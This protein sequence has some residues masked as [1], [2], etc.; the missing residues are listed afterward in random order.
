MHSGKLSSLL[1][2]TSF[3]LAFF[4]IS[5]I[6]AAQTGTVRGTV[7]DPNGL[8][9]A[10]A[11][12]I[13]EGTK[14]GTVTDASGNYTLRVPPGNYTLIISYVGVKTQRLPINVPANG[15]VDNTFE[16]QN[17]GDLN[18]VI[19]VGSRSATPRSSTQTPVPVDVI[20]ARELTLTGQV[21]PT[22]MLNFV[23]PSFN[24]SRQ[25]V[26]DGT[27]HIDPATLRGL[28]PDQ[29]LVLVNGRRRYNTALL[30][31]NG[32]IGRGSVGTDMN[33]IPPEAIERIEVL[34]DGASSQ[35]GSDAI[36]GVINVV[37]KKNNKGTTLYGHLGQQYAGDGQVMQVGLNHGMKIG[38]S[39]YL[40]ISGDL[41]HRDPTNRS[42]DY[43]N[44]VYTSNVA[45]DNQII[46][47]RHFSRKNN[48]HIGNSELDNAGIVVNM[49]APLGKNLQF[50]LTSI[51]NWR[52]G[53]AAGFYR[54]PKQTSQVITALYP[55][56]FL[57]VINSRI[58]D[59]SIIAGIDGKFGRGWN[60]DLSQ[61]SGGN[62]FAFNISNTN[63]ASLYS[64]GKNSPT[65]FYAG[66]LR[67]NQHTTNLNFARD[68]GKEMGLKS[69]NVAT[70][71]ELRFDNYQI[72]QGE[73][74]SYKNYD[75]SSGKV[76]G[77]Q[78]FPGFQP[79]N[80]VN[81][82]RTVGGAY[83]D[84]E[85][86]LTE[87]FLADIAGRYEHY[88]DYGSSFAGKLA[89]RYRFV[90]AFSLR[91]AVSNGFRAPSMHQRY[92]SAIS[93]VFIS[94]GSGLQPFQQ[95]TFRNNSLVAQ[96]FGIPSLGPEK[97]MNYSV[98]FTSKFLRNKINLTVDAYQID[99]KNRIVLSS[100]FRRTGGAESGAV[101]TILSQYPELN[102]VTSVIFFTNA[103]DTRT[104]GIDIVTSF[105]DKV[106]KGDFTF[107]VAGNFNET[108]VQGDPKVANITDPALKARLFARDEKSR[109]EEAQPKNKFSFNLN[110][111]ISKWILNGRTTR[112]GSVFTKDPGNPALDEDFSPKWVT[113]ASLAYRIKNFAT[114]SVGANNIGNVYPDKL[115]E[116][117]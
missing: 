115:G 36:A 69:F 11:S 47:E 110:Y 23:A 39:G 20:T 52:E 29:V 77:A 94:T 105:N 83:V 106:G 76:G 98:G 19:V 108:V 57:P 116:Y 44:T 92:F 3:L 66:K 24:S 38:K 114:L 15:V 31:V 6:V 10:G 99:I 13:L 58:I 109:I 45:M 78:V 26:A 96:A 49:G 22:Q 80:A 81:Q 95:G 87:N 111:R 8:P 117:W 21:E 68:F 97:S 73:E 103:V 90:D 48:M 12:V 62:S 14:R 42:G 71:A 72:E 107:T 70:G 27:D 112:F 56:G 35:Y 51:L 85:S 46:A 28:G 100:S 67:F 50:F 40:N 33:A 2:R 60:W 41:R 25:T 55:D 37:L 43:T 32:T 82:T 5:L 18:R 74:A 93:T 4:L 102:D 64:L 54:Y 61:A 63:N 101:N 79:A 16:M 113:D 84:L 75:P 65:S 59:R 7:K 1:Q 17:S 88:S 30:N 53:K 104:R 91:A 34:R 86:D 89:L 9:L